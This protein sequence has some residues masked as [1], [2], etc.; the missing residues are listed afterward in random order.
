MGSRY[1]SVNQF[2]TLNQFLP[3]RIPIFEIVC[4]MQE[5]YKPRIKLYIYFSFVDLEK[6]FD[7]VLRKVLWWA[8]RKLLVPEWL[9]KFIQAMYFNASSK[10]R[11]ESSYSDSCGVNVEV[12][13]Q[14]V[15][16]PLLF[17]IVLEALSQEFCTGRPWG[18]LYADG[19]V[20]MKTKT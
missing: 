3:N 6:A 4:Q 14:S 2:E 11:V 15:L 12:H 8:L 19:L 17:I 9:V 13:Q 5:K 16:S 18:I 1:V 20:N 10:V 7:R